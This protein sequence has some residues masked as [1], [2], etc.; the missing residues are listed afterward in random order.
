MFKKV[1]GSLKN[2]FFVDNCCL[3]LLLS[4]FHLFPNAC[5][6]NDPLLQ[7][8]L[9]VACMH[10]PVYCCD[11]RGNWNLHEK[12]CYFPH[13]L[14]LNLVHSLSY[15]SLGFGLCCVGFDHG[16]L[17]SLTIQIRRSLLN[18]DEY[19]FRRAKRPMYYDEGLEVI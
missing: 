16:L 6:H 12:A 8:D 17:C 4:A 14:C 3:C 5:V 11:I 13:P 18:E 7:P 10:N 15:S 2:C 1:I 19:G 9:K